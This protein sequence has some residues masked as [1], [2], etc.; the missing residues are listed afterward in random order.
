MDNLPVIIQI[1]SLLITIATQVCLLAYFWGK[2]AEKVDN[3]K[4]DRNELMASIKDISHGVYNLTLTV[5]EHGRKIQALET[6]RDIV[7]PNIHTKRN[8]SN[9]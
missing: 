6:W 2:F 9:G 7:T 5:N 1:V 8:G 4:E 3:L